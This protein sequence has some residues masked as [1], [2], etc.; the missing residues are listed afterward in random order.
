MLAAEFT[1]SSDLDFQRSFESVNLWN[2]GSPGVTRI[3]RLVAENRAPSHR[4]GA[5]REAKESPT[6][7]RSLSV[8]AVL[9]ANVTREE[10]LPNPL[11]I[12][13]IRHS[14]GAQGEL[15]C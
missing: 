5:F 4:D 11:L 6:K 1:A 8:A 7:D 12:S 2:L 10:H 9:R 3:R 15:W 13:V 14:A